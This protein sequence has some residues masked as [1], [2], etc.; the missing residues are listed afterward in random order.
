MMGLFKPI[1][2]I[3]GHH[4]KSNYFYAVVAFERWGR[5]AHKS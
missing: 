5:L 3:S 2:T 4:K 1:L